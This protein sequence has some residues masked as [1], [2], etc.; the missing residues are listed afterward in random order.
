MSDQDPRWEWIEITKFGDPGPVYMKGSCNHLDV[1]PVDARDWITRSLAQDG[2]IIAHLCLTCDTQV[3][4]EW[5][6]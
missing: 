5:R 3:P 6:P 2:E 4:A 1:V